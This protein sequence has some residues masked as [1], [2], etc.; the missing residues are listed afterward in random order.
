MENEAL[1]L[2][3]FATMGEPPLPSNI[4]EEY[5][6][7]VANDGAIV[8]GLLNYPLNAPITQ[9]A[10]F[11]HE[12]TGRKDGG[13]ME[14]IA[15]RYAKVGI[16]S[17]RIDFSGHGERKD[18]WERYSPIE[19]ARDAKQSIDY[20]DERFPDI[21]KTIV[22]GFSTGGSIAIML[23]VFDE[24]ISKACLLYPVLSY[25]N[26]FIAAAYPENELEIPSDLLDLDAPWRAVEF[27]KEKITACLDNNE[28]FVLGDHTYGAKFIKDC[29]E[30]VDE[31]G[32]INNMLCE[33]NKGP[34]TI[35]QGTHDFAIPYFLTSV[36]HHA[37]LHSQAPFRLIT[38]Q[39]MNHF[40][41]PQWKPSI[42][43]QFKK[44]ALQEDSDFN[45]RHTLIRLKNPPSHLATVLLQ[46]TKG[47][48]PSLSNG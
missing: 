13:T 7:F 19:M 44:A 32:D 41:P 3:Q 47:Q 21:E 26:N 40:V 34:L 29:K 20:L 15:R 38:M 45:P 12:I 11:L 30:V 1:D 6:T 28:P 33:P 14:V 35:I 23:R 46:Q 22:T 37:S 17:L 5:I 2:G 42:W 48:D 9:K 24:R 25:K 18:E 36:Y 4:A 8:K 39:K 16:A 10:L 27:T 31:M 43:H